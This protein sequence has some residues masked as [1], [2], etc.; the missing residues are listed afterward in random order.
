MTIG[1]SSN[2]PDAPNDPAD[3]VSIM[4]SNAAAISSIISVDHVGFNVAGGG[5]HAQVTFNA[6][7]VPVPPV[8]PPILF[9][10]TV[11]GTP[12]LFYYAGNAAHSSTQY[13]AAT[14]GSTFVLGGIIFKWGI[15]N[16][17]TNTAVSFTSAFPNNCYTVML[18]PIS[19]GTIIGSIVIGVKSGSVSTSG[20]TLLTNQG[21]FLV[22][23]YYLAIGN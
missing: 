14:S 8:S 23:F 13:V 9:T 6:N 20:F 19:S 3:D 21:V 5:Q 10:N 2:I 16:A 15:G 7:N 18:T 4:K 1:Y 22:D 12:Q 11:A 17:A